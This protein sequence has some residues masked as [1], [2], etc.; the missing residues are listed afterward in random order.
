MSENESKYPYVTALRDPKGF[1]R[2]WKLV[3]LLGGLAALGAIA[4]GLELA[5]RREEPPGII[6]PERSEVAGRTVEVLFPG[7]TAGWVR[8][9]REI[10][11]AER[12]EVMIRRLVEELVKG[13]TSKA[14]SVFPPS[15]R[16]Q[17]VFWDPNGELTVIF[18]E[19]LRSEHPGGSR[20]ETATI[21]SL[22]GSVE[23]NFPEVQ[24]L[25]VLIEGEVVASLAGHVDLS[26]PLDTFIPR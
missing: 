23:L 13:P 6:P 7:E 22:L 4:F 18:S 21:E 10:L 5:L 25:R 1:L 11:A 9:S 26:R 20:A 2:G 8:E 17:D 12:R 3:F 19:S 14:S 24:R 16:V 15:T